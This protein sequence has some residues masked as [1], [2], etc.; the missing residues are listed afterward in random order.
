[1][2]SEET[3]MGT[4]ERRE[5]A[6]DATRQKILDAARELFAR[7]GYEAVSMRRI[8]DAIEYSPTAIYVY[9]KD[10]ADL[11]KELCFQ[12]FESFTDRAQQSAAVPDPVERIRLLGR[13]YIRFAIEHPNHFRLMFMTKLA[14]ELVETDEEKLREHGRGDPSRDGY[15]FLTECV[16]DAIARGYIREDLEQD[17][18]LVAQILWAGV[19][20]VASLQ[21]TRPDNEP[22]FN[23]KG[24][25]LLGEAASLAVLRGVLRSEAVPGLHASMD[26]SDTRNRLG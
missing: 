19:H 17:P 24:A 10:K 21:V 20:G 15:A 22:W 16:R 7:D 11:M 8:A 6:K 5:R 4:R 13:T 23:W 1:M 25:E 3:V 2:F 26:F 9:F 14:P 12:D 18:E